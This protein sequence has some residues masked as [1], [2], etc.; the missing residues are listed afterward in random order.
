MI[1][2]RSHGIRYGPLINT[3]RTA[4]LASC[5]REQPLT[6]AVLPF[7]AP[8]PYRGC[9]SIR[10]RAGDRGTPQGSPARLHCSS[11]APHRYAICCYWHLRRKHRRSQREHGSS[12]RSC[13]SPIWCKKRCQ[14]CVGK[15]WCFSHRGRARRREGLGG[16]LNTRL[17]GRIRS[18]T[19][20][21]PQKKAA[22][23]AAS[24]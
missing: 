20:P 17:A 13:A 19:T 10:C 23:G 16:D 24:F 21:A 9:A 8:D 12:A 15:I 6:P 2:P 1:C 5:R 3:L 14:R 11:T 4:T 22:L 7:P 18:R